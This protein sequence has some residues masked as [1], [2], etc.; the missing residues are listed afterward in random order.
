MAAFVERRR[1]LD[2]TTGHAARGLG[3]ALG[4]AERKAAR[5]GWCLGFEQDE[6][7]V[8]GSWRWPD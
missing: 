5:M 7:G 8:C 6:R 2:A 3:N 1:E 4:S